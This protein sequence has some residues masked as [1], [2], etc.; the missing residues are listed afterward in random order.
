[1]DEMGKVSVV[2]YISVAVLIFWL[3]SHSPNKLVNRSHDQP[4]RRLKLRSSFTFTG[5]NDHRVTFDP[6]V[7][8]MERRREDKEWEKLQLHNRHPEF[9]PAPAAESQPEW[10][11]FMNAEDYLNDE[12]RFNV[13][14]RLV[15]LFPK[16][17]VDPADG[18]VSGSELTQW[19]VKQSE[20]EVLHRTQREVELHDKNND[21][22]VSFSEYEP[23]SWVQNS[24]NT[25][26]LEFE[27][28]CFCCEL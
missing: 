25:E 21:G 12:D 17:D 18:F 1:M 7:A 10:E 4:A 20:K 11:D 9:D 28:W 8:D 14:G 5:D 13:T 27:D 16:I 2:I 22:L 15:L 19:N 23:P 3:V 24:G 6:I 26:I